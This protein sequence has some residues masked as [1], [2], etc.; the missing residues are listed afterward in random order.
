VRL[1]AGFRRADFTNQSTAKQY[2]NP[3][4]PEAFSA[5]RLQPRDGCEEFQ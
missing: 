2:S 5:S 1:R 4:P 3:A